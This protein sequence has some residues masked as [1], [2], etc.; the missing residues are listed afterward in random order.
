MQLIDVVE[1]KRD[2][3]RNGVYIVLLKHLKT[4]SGGGGKTGETLRLIF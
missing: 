2:I 1:K 4:L 3:Y